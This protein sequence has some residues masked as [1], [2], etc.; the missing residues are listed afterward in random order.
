MSKVR[1]IKVLLN[2]I[3]KYSGKKV[4]IKEFISE[5]GEEPEQDITKFQNLFQQ[6]YPT[7]I[8]NLSTLIKDKKVLKFLSAGLKDGKTMDDKFGL[9]RTVISCKDLTP[10]QSEVDI[11]KSLNFPLKDVAT[12]EM[13]L[14]GDNVLLGG[15]PIVTFNK[16]YVIDGHHRWSQAFCINPD[17][18]M[19][20]LNL[21]KANLSPIE[22]LKSTQVAVATTIGDI[23]IETVEGHNLFEAPREIVV[24]FVLEHITDEVVQ[25]FVNLKGFKSK[26]QIAE[27][28]WRNCEILQK[29]NRPIPNAPNRGLMPQ[30]GSNLPGVVKQLVTGK[31]NSKEPFAKPG[32][33]AEKFDYY[34]A[35][36]NYSKSFDYDDKDLYRIQDILDKSKNN[37]QKRTALARNMANKITDWDKALRRGYAAKSL[38]LDGIAELFFMRAKQLNPGVRIKRKVSVKEAALIKLIEKYSGKKVI[39]KESYFIEDDTK[40]FEPTQSWSYFIADENTWEGEQAV[41]GIYNLC[42]GSKENV[43]EEIKMNTSENVQIEEKEGFTYIH[44]EEYDVILAK[45]NVS[46]KALIHKLQYMA[47]DNSRGTLKESHLVFQP[48]HLLRRAVLNH[49]ISID[50]Y[51]DSKFQDAAKT[52]AERWAVEDDYDGDFGSSDM[53][54]ATKEFLDEL[55]I[56]NSFID[57]KLTRLKDDGTPYKLYEGVKKTLK[58]YVDL[59]FIKAKL[60]FDKVSKTFYGC[61]KNFQF[62]TTYTI[63]NPKT[64][65]R[66]KF[67]LVKQTGPEFDPN[68][69]YIYKSEDDYTFEVS[70]NEQLTKERADSYLKHKL[71]KEGK[72]LKKK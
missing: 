54:F 39:I 58:E 7:F 27:Y 38:N 64:G 65:G 34:N 51:H 18:K 32:V 2:L 40:E 1:K 26:E 53:T 60:T 57:N 8:D 21:T 55:G 44:N 43:I 69:K 17:A 37:P 52:I 9:G 70:Q 23:P 45:G 19:A 4:F 24:K 49:L 50:E 48:N 63:V 28:I 42:R 20:S 66:K 47:D 36:G 33:V 35:K 68:T 15:T 11:S 30:T 67:D 59:D 71:R 29:N 25:V 16:G 14:K 5:D 41:D 62:A 31:A 61:D 13:C 12:A 72:N 3:E 46:K 6:D 56:K 10:T 22:A